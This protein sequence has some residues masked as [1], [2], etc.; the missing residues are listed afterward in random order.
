[1]TASLC[2]YWSGGC[3]T[4]PLLFI[5]EGP[6]AEICAPPRGLVLCVLLR[7]RSDVQQL[8]RPGG[9]LRPAVG[10]GNADQRQGALAHA[11]APQG[12]HAVLCDH[13][14]HIVS[15]GRKE[16]LPR[17][18]PSA[19]SGPKKKASVSVCPAISGPPTAAYRPQRPL[20]STT[21]RSRGAAVCSRARMDAGSLQSEAQVTTSPLR[22]SSRHWS[23]VASLEA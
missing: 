19:R 17:R 15:V 16:V 8:F 22:S 7:S 23:G 2:G 13:V 11:A 5:M 9:E 10:M 21:P 1:M 18:K 14:V 20:R 6:A 3:E 4:V 12:G